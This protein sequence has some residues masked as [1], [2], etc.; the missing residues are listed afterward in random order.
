MIARH[1]SH[2]SEPWR[3]ERHSAH[4]GPGLYCDAWGFLGFFNSGGPD[5][6]NA[7]RIVACI[8]ACAGLPTEELERIGKHAPFTNYATLYSAMEKAVEVIKQWHNMGGAEGVWQI[9]YDNAP[10]MKPIRDA[11][12]AKATS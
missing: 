10:E 5:E 8:N 12:N 11:L 1:G 3:V 2:S 7:R 6:A 4:E 9:Y